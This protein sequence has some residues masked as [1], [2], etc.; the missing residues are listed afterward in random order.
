MLADQIIPIQFS[1]SLD[2]KSNPKLVILGKF[3]LLEN[4]IFTSP[5]SLKK[6]NGYSVV[7]SAIVGGGN[8]VQ[9]QL[10]KAFGSGKIQELIVVD[11]N[12]LYSYSPTLL[13]WIN[14]GAYTSVDLLES[15]IF[16]EG[17]I[18]GHTDCA[19]LGNI[20]IYSWNSIQSLSNLITTYAT[21][22]DISANNVL[23]PPTVLST[24]T[25]STLLTTSPRCVVL[26]NSALAVTYLKSDTT[27]IVMRVL[28][29]S[30]AGI[31]FGSEIAIASSVY[32]S[33]ISQINY[34]IANTSSGAALVYIAPSATTPQTVG[35]VTINT[36][37]AVSHSTTFTDAGTSVAA[38]HL[39]VDPT[40]G[41]IWI[42]WSITASTT[43]F[44]KYAIYSSTLATVLAT[45]GIQSG[46]FAQLNQISAYSISTSGQM[47]F[48]NLATS[49][50][51]S[52]GI[53]VL[54]DQTYSC[55]AGVTGASTTPAS[56]L[57]SVA[58]FSRV[59]SIGTRKYIVFAYRGGSASINAGF[60]ATQ[61]TFFVID[62]ATGSVVARFAAGNA[63]GAAVK[64]LGWMPQASAISGSKFLYACG[65]AYQ[66]LNIPGQVIGFTNTFTGLIGA[67][68]VTLDFASARSNRAVPVG[69]VLALNGACPA[70]YDG[71]SVSEL[72]FNVFPEILSTAITTGSGFISAGTRS[73][74]A[75]LQWPD[76]Q[77]RLHQS[78]PSNPVQVITTASANTITLILNSLN[79][80]EKN[81]VNIA[82]Y[83]TQDAGTIYYLV[84][85][86]AQL[87]FNNEGSLT[88]T[89]TDV[90]EDSNLPGRPELYTTG[91]VL[92]NTVPPPSMIME[93]RND[94]LWL[95]D[96]ENPNTIWYT[97]SDQKGVGLSPSGFLTMQIDQKFGNIVALSEMDEKMIVMKLEGNFWFAGDGADDTGANS[98]LSFPQA[99]PSDTGCKTLKSVILT[100]KGIMRQTEKGM[101]LLDRAMNDHYFDDYFDGAAVEAFNSQTITAA[102]LIKD[103]NQ[104]RFLTASGT[105]L[106]FD[107]LMN[108]W[109]TFTN[110]L[111]YAADNWNGLYVYARTD[112]NVFQENLTTFLDNTTPLQ[113]RAQLGPLALGSI[114]GFQRARR[115]QMAGDFKN[116]NSSG[117][118]VQI[119]ANYDFQPAFSSPI[120]YTFGAASASGTFEYE[121]RFPIQKCGA[122]G[123][124][125]EEIVTGASGEWM[126]IATMGILAGVKKG[127]NKLSSN[128][129]VG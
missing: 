5:T 24:I 61:P 32:I 40:N 86:P 64:S 84:T 30:L 21:V 109:G 94:R 117:H 49:Q 65:I 104:A 19:V 11:N 36:S 51:T 59:F 34:D 82:L 45:V 74:I 50:A 119:S 1:K 126:E 116:G 43:T 103:K 111:G 28:S 101:Y 33:G 91:N 108:K 3:V 47:V 118:G 57:L 25:S 70:I 98:S 121:E 60:F 115:A 29:A 79:L 16:Q 97:K 2:T 87:T 107:Y 58:P 14:K 15:F 52:S 38:I 80:T 120:P 96:D 42:Y 31:S 18:S 20:A 72:G 6:R 92:E 22:V 69:G 93:A 113:M 44:L 77:G 85:N 7:P 95:V 37:G 63:N 13:G 106:V 23:L 27:A 112:G 76:A 88:I 56:F 35:A 41:N 53:N 54:L 12:V 122:L 78:T 62:L 75:V 83:R 89:I 100:P 114:N 125:I 128:Q 81:N 102:T 10:V 90:M 110:H 127:L 4:A 66:I 105:T 46:T 55:T 73:Y 17:S 26:G 71:Q 99:L 39:C 124:L 9:P 68:S 123:L 129:R 48:F 67:A 8:L